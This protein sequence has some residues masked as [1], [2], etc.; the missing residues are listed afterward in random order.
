MSVAKSRCRGMPSSLSCS[1]MHES[2]ASRQMPM[3]YLNDS[4]LVLVPLYWTWSPES[5]NCTLL[6]NGE[7]LNCNFLQHAALWWVEGISWQKFE[8]ICRYLSIAEQ[9]PRAW[10]RCKWTTWYVFPEK[11]LPRLRASDKDSCCFLVHTGNY[12][13][14]RRTRR[15]EKS[16]R[17][18][19]G[20]KACRK[21]LI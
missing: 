7:T 21:W 15:H 1:S 11:S 4:G 16:K 19:N 20:P 17:Y 10:G 6:D 12:G 14:E 13:R 8:E 5:P 18:R 3:R 9:I 2:R